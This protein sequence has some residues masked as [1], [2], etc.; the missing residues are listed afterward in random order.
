M[1][2]ASYTLLPLSLSL[3]FSSSEKPESSEVPA[4]YIEEWETPNSPNQFSS[5][6][7]VRTIPLLGCIRT[8]KRHKEELVAFRPSSFW[9]I[10][11]V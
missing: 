4:K 11:K 5:L 9:Y 7:E 2:R 8:M 3:F 10:R 1:I 6:A